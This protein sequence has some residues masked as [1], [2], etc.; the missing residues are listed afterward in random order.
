MKRLLPLPAIRMFCLL[1]GISTLTAAATAGPVGVW[2]NRAE[3]FGK[4]TLVLFPSGRGLISSPVASN[5]L[6]WKQGDGGELKAT[7]Y[8][9]DSRRIR[10][11]YNPADDRMAL[12]LDK[13]SPAATLHRDSVDLPE[14][15]VERLVKQEKTR[16][17][18]HWTATRKHFERLSLGARPTPELM[19]IWQRE[20]RKPGFVTLIANP[21]A[22]KDAPYTTPPLLS[23]ARR[24]DQNLLQLAIESA[25]DPELPRTSADLAPYERRP[26]PTLPVTRYLSPRLSHAVRALLQSGALSYQENRFR[27]DYLQGYRVGIE[28][29]IM[30]HFSDE[31]LA[32]TL[33]PLL[34]EIAREHPVL[35]VYLLRKRNTENTAPD[36]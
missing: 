6:S 14:D 8:G 4:V 24:K 22:L 35:E 1:L 33:P 2:S 5:L 28:D 31:A 36:Q 18:Q 26:L 23:M 9:D 25:I 11:R 17:M 7:V 12:W 19:D 3:G 27:L 15:P 20:S 10:L 16:L 13:E 21:T 34:R 29:L 30:A 32:R